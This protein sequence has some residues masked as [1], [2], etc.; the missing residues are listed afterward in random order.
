MRQCRLAFVAAAAALAATSAVSVAPAVSASAGPLGRARPKSTNAFPVV[1]AQPGTAIPKTT[2]NFGMRPVANDV[3]FVS[4]IKQGWFKDVGISIAPAPDG[5][6]ST[7]DNAVPLLLNNQL[8]IEALDPIPTISTLGTESSIRFIG[9]S[10]IFLGYQILA[11][12]S[13]HAKTVSDF[14]KQGLSFKNAIAKTLDQM[15]GQTLTIPPIISDRG[16]LDTAFAAGGLTLSNTVH[17]TVT[18]DSNALN[19]ASGGHVKFVSFDGAP[20]TA[21][22]LGAGWTPIV[23]PLDLS[24]NLPPGVTSPAELL[25]EPPGIATTATWASQNPDTVLR[26][27][28]VM[29][30]LISAIDSSPSKNL[31]YE[32]GYL[33]AFA[34]THLT[35]KELQSNILKLD[36]LISF[37]QQAPYFNS[38]TSALYYKNWFEATLNYDVKHG[39]LPKGNYSAD[40]LIWAGSVYH[41]LVNYQHKTQALLA[42]AGKSHLSAK[43]ESLVRQA[44]KYYSWFDFLDSYRFAKAAVA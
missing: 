5:N 23:T 1:A 18:P 26:F 35:I 9:L 31:A 21:Q 27:V 11:A 37:Q 24:K 36:P 10:D 17:V 34:G 41:E 44:K 16:F 14:M 6:R 13:V 20:F 30:R 12:P 2:V 33:N 32:L 25:V 19:L 40:N 3:M 42:K 22:L 29:F 15:K 28:S 39:A 7:F 43:Q 4:A 8:N 38:P